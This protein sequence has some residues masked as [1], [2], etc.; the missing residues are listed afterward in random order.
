MSTTL[1]LVTV[2]ARLRDELV[3][4]FDADGGFGDAPKF[5]RPSYV[6]A[7]L[8]SRRPTRPA[9]RGRPD[10]GRHVASGSL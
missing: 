7:L 8:A 10:T 5:P 2:R 6:E 9:L 3:D 4:R 1:D